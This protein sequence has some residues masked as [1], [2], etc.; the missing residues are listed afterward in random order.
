[1]PTPNVNHLTNPQ[2]C[3]IVDLYVHNELHRKILKRKLC[4]GLTYEK[5]AEEFDFS[6]CFAKKVVYSYAHL[7]AA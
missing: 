7:F 3:E 6:V 2:I 1:M 5:I 4:D